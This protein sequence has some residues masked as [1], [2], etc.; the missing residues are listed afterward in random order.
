MEIEITFTFYGQLY[1]F[2]ITG[3]HKNGTKNFLRSFHAYENRDKAK[4]GEIIDKGDGDCDIDID[5]D[6][7]DNCY[8]QGCRDIITCIGQ[9]F[10]KYQRAIVDYAIY[11]RDKVWPKELVSYGYDQMP[12]DKYITKQAC[13]S[14]VNGD[15]L[16]PNIQ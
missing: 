12:Y 14:I 10:E 9:I 1:T 5:K 13:N 4:F 7:R 8:E 2:E 16:A 3:W 11:Y 6:Q 15:F